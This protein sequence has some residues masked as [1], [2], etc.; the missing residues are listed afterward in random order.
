MPS[1]T[2]E[3]LLSLDREVVKLKDITRHE[4]AA[5]PQACLKPAE[6]QDRP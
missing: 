6:R 4:S 5:P 2:C 1:E 3:R